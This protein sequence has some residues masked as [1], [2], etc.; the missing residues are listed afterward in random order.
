MMLRLL[1]VSLACSLG[2]GFL[3]RNRPASLIDKESSGD[4]K[5]PLATIAKLDALK[6]K[7]KLKEGGYASVVDWL[8]ENVETSRKSESPADADSQHVAL[9]NNATAADNATVSQEQTCIF[10]DQMFGMNSES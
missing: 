8:L 3:H 7:L 1:I 6:D 2:H 10:D 4:V 9:H 5:L